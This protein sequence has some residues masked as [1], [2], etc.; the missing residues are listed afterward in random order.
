MGMSVSNQ[1]L[2]TLRITK[3][4]ISRNM[5]TLPAKI[6]PLFTHFE[7]WAGKPRKLLIKDTTALKS[8]NLEL[9]SNPFAQLLSSP[10]RLDRISKV[11]LPK[12]LS[13]Q[14]G[15]NI[16]SPNPSMKFKVNS[17]FKDKSRSSHSYILNKL[18][19]LEKNLKNSRSA[20]PLHVLANLNNE[21]KNLNVKFN[22]G[23]LL[24][25]YLSDTKQEIIYGLTRLM[26]IRTN[27]SK[28]TSSNII[29]KYDTS[30]NKTL[31]IDTRITCYEYTLTFNLAKI[32]DSQLECIFN[33]AH[34]QLYLNEKSDMAIILQI[35]RLLMFLD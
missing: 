35:Y 2:R 18:S 27:S 10:T 26:T 34:Q 1:L 3:S 25:E 11:K 24:D 6:S 15:T 9:N 22:S 28:P 23:E 29:V 13:I 32:Q 16:K 7:K 12:L 14:V 20:L 33:K 5:P 31:K 21:N 30:D 19:V 8:F 17:N 4:N